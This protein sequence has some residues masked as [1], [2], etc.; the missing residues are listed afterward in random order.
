MVLDALLKIKNEQD[1]SLTLR[2]SCRE[3]I[4]GSCAMNID[5]SNGL[6]C[7]TFIEGKEHD[8]AKD[9]V[10]NVNKGTCN[11]FSIFFR[12]YLLPFLPFKTANENLSS[13]TYGCT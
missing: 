11:V 7:L 12:T 8:K 9:E 4:C 2:R 10:C 3:G 5:G 1:P 6:A 13:S